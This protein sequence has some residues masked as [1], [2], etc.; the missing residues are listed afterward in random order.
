MQLAR[1]NGGGG[2]CVEKATGFRCGAN[3]TP[4]EFKGTRVV[5][6][7]LRVSGCC[8][9]LILPLTI[10]SFCLFFTPSLVLGR[11][12]NFDDSIHDLHELDEANNELNHD[13]NRDLA[14]HDLQFMTHNS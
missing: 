6:L 3:N 9:F 13:P 7:G 12:A 4:M 8:Y 10:C 14:N 2:H 5:G 11:I 1:G